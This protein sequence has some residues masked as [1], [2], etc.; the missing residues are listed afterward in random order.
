MGRQILKDFVK[1]GK[2][3]KQRDSHTQLF[4]DALL[5][6]DRIGSEIVLRD[7]AAQ[8]QSFEDVERVITETLVIIGDGWEA[9]DYSLFQIYMSGV[10]CEETIARMLPEFRIERKNSPKIGIGVL[11]DRHALGKRIVK[12]VV[13]AEGFEIFDFGDGLSVDEMVD[14]TMAYR[15]DVLMVSTL[16]LPSALK[17]KGIRE[18]FDQRK[19]KTRLIVGGA[20]FRFDSS[21]WQQVGADA[22]GKNATAVISIIERLV[23]RQ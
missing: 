9:G 19:L 18:Q 14:K 3:M 2:Q 13:Q 1:V 7:V 16:M 15:I 23:D 8:H 17:V 20:P 21:L 10:I 11:I 22:D 5:S 6:M 12:A 4:L